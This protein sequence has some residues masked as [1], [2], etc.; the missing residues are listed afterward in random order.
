G[1]EYI[2]RDSKPYVSLV[3]YK[4]AIQASAEKF[5]WSEKWKGWHKPTAVN[6]SKRI[7]VGCSIH[8]NA[9]VGE[10][11]SEAIVTL[12]PNGLA[13]IHAQV[14]EFGNGQRSSICKMAAEV[15]DMDYDKV[16]LSRP[17]SMENPEEFG[18][19]GSRGT[20]TLGS[21]V[22]N[23]CENAKIKLYAAAA[24][25]LRCSINDLA[26]KDGYVFVKEE[27]ERRLTWFE[28]MGPVRSI[29]AYGKYDVDYSAPNFCINFIE[30]E[31][32][33]DTGVVKIQQIVTGTDVGQIIDSKAVDGQLQGGLGAACI[34]TEVFEETV[35]D[36]YT[37]RIM[38]NNLIDYKW[39]PF[40]EF[41]DFDSIVLE[42]QPS[43][44]KFRAVGV[45][46]ISGAAGA[47]AI[48]MAISNAIEQDYADYPATPARILNALGK[49]KK[50]E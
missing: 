38:T 23:A 6:G 3:D 11:N 46:E 15:L 31:V 34:D 16:Q 22:V 14:P 20:L 4:D 25:I 30:V 47:S 2:W 50:G 12:R 49:A 37:G 5:G 1:D 36:K 13:V 28:A 18:L 42:G 7:G 32:D 35:V 48:A 17:N 26:T 8:G 44:S 27:P 40:N 19:A 39:R 43:I 21:A 9:D 41:P 29:S 24:P 33:T 45:G 10:D